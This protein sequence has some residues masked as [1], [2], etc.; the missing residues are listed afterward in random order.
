MVCAAHRVCIPASRLCVSAARAAVCS[1][2]GRSFSQKSQEGMLCS[3]CMTLNNICFDYHI[4][5]PGSGVLVGL[6]PARWSPL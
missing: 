5:I 4:S 6:G 1:A 2:L 3:S